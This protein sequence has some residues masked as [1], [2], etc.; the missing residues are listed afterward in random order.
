MK[1][2]KIGDKV[3]ISPNSKFYH[4]QE[5]DDSNNPIPLTITEVSGSRYHYNTNLHFLYDDEDLLPFNNKP[6]YEIY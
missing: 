3:L 5:F 1:R 2:F 4:Q 6:Q